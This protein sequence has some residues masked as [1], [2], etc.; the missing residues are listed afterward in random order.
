MA[1]L[2]TF[3]PYCFFSSSTIFE[4]ISGITSFL[5]DS[6]VLDLDLDADLDLDLGP[7]LESVLDLVET[8]D[9]EADLEVDLLLA[10]VLEFDFWG[11]LTLVIS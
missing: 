4:K 9:L 8:V 1:K 7:F 10:G 5:V 6:Y 2:N 3:P 11:N